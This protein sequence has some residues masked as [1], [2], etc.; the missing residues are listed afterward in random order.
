MTRKAIDNSQGRRTRIGLALGSGSARGLAHLGVIRAIEDAGIEVDFIA[1]TS[2]GAFIGAIFASG[3][4]DRLAADLLDFDWKSITSLL[5]LV[6]PRS[7]LIDGQKI[8]GFVRAHVSSA[9]IEDLSIPFRAVATDLM[10][11]KEVVIGTGDLIE[12]VRASIS[13]P[14]ILTPVRSDGRILVDGGLVNPV[15]VS[16]VRAMGADLVI[17]VDLNHDIVASR[18]SP[19][20]SLANGKLY[21]N[22]VTRMLESLQSIESPALSQVQCM[23][24]Q[25]TTTG[26]IRR[27]A[28]L[29]IHYASTHHTC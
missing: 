29:Y 1:G 6:F 14:G 18:L 17:A 24:T 28:G 26:D 3:N 4:L 23:V 13:V 19:P 7:G 27:T 22:A 16:T 9:S 2:M 12:A 10:N 20:N 21:A 8:A 5:D 25:G 11:G 15:P